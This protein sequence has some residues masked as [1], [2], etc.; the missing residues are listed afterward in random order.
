MTIAS[1]GAGRSWDTLEY[2]Q[3]VSASYG[4]GELVVGFADG[5]EAR[6]SV[7]NLVRAD[8]PVPDWSKVRAEQYHVTVPSS[9]GDIEIPWDVI[10]VQT[11]PAFDAYWEQLAL[12]RTAPGAPLR[13]RTGG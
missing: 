4:G 7:A 12:A 11:D 5:T 13:G 10:R 8:G 2:Q 1:S 6:L 3:I 9:G